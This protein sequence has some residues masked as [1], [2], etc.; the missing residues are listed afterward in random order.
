MHST[1]FPIGPFG[2]AG[3]RSSFAALVLLCTPALG[4]SSQDKGDESSASSPA[5]AGPRKLPQ[6]V[7]VAGA[8][9]QSGFSRGELRIQRELQAFAISKHPVT[10]VEF[11]TCVKAGACSE[12]DA[13]VCG[14]AAYRPHASYSALSWS[15][16]EKNAPAVCVGEDQ[17]E[18]FCAWIGGRLPTPDEWLL[19]ARGESPK[20]YSWGDEASSC[21]Q[22]PLAGELADHF[23]NRIGAPPAD[24]AKR[25]DCPAVADDFTPEVAQHQGGAS[26]SEMEDVLLTP[27]ELLAGDPESMFNACGRDDQHCVV[28]GLEPAA[29]DSVEPFFEASAGSGGTHERSIAH[30]YGFRCVLESQDEVTP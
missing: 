23:N 12:S 1:N 16:K 7:N 14:D 26:P 15:K 24:P 22:H 8:A 27:G 5:P 20:R 29:I 6:S 2:H 10:W 3:A 21:D 25:L 19:A 17:A 11:G 28:F 30:A 18:S 4:C 9:V 13:S